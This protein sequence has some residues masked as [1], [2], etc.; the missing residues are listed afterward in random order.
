[1]TSEFPDLMPKEG[2]NYFFGQAENYTA[3]RKRLVKVARE[4][5]DGDIP[6]SGK[7]Q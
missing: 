5:I 2:G 4:A 7:S 1:V 6:R 3:E